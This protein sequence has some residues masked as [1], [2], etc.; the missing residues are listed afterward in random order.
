[1]RELTVTKRNPK[2]TTSSDAARFAAQP[3]KAPGT[4]LNSRKRNMQTIM[5]SEPMITTLME[6]SFSVRIGLACPAAPGR[7]V[8]SPAV[9]AL[10]MVGTVL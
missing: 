3:T 2:T 4:G 8:F 5:S 6:R 9:R 7:M 10:T 1:M